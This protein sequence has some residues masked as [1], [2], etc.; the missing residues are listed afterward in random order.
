MPDVAHVVV[1]VFENREETA[2][3]GNKV[4]PTFNKYARRYVSF[5]HYTAVAHPSLPNYLALVSGSTHGITEDCDTCG[6][7]QQSVGGLL[8]R[9]GKSW[10]GFAEGF[11]SSDLFAKR[12]MPF[13]YFRDGASHVHPL[14]KLDDRRL[15]SYAFVA[16]NICHDGHNCSLATADAFLAHWL[17]PLLR[18][19][20]T[21]VFVVFD[22]GT[23]NVGGGGRVAAFAA[24]TAVKRRGVVQR[25]VDHYTVLRTVEY[26]FGLPLLGRTATQRPLAGIFR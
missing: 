9:A 6:P 24:G 11:P 25:H 13:L 4:A 15:P 22:E 17:P 16:P 12:H 10:G 7:W 18:A 20:H 5:A 8:T 1:V 14:S 26:L 23:T 19:A 3:V 21:A 2:V